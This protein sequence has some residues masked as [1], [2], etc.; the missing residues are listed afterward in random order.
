MTEKS[1][2][3]TMQDLQEEL[4]GEE[5]G[6][7]AP[8]SEAAGPDG[9]G[10][11]GAM[12]EDLDINELIN[13]VGGPENFA[14]MVVDGA[15]EW[16]K[17][18]SLTPMNDLQGLLIKKGLGACLVKWNFST[19]AAPEWILAGGVLWVIYDKYTER[20]KLLKEKKEAPAEEGN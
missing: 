7:E 18:N 3:G 12:P 2:D 15:N 5:A 8:G 6:K 16:L 11:S 10:A 17:K 13:Q 20:K 1:V 14:A 9:G 19:K 4:E